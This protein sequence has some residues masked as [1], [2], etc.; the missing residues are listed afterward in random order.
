[1]DASQFVC[2]DINANRE[3]WD[4]AV[5]RVFS[6]CYRDDNDSAT[7][8][9]CLPPPGCTRAVLEAYRIHI[10]AVNYFTDP[11]K[12]SLGD[13]CRRLAKTVM[14]D[15]ERVKREDDPHGQPSSE[16]YGSVQE[17]YK[18]EVEAL[19]G[20]ESAFRKS[21][22]VPYQATRPCTTGQKRRA[23]RRLFASEISSDGSSETPTL[24]GSGFPSTSCN[25]LSH[26]TSPLESSSDPCLSSN[27]TSL[28]TSS[29]E[30]PSEIAPSSV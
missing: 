19:Y 11:I 18:A 30:S 15:L 4:D 9:T 6:R 2:P 27:V 13:R 26:I 8:S 29:S 23:G 24:P 3:N 14:A 10:E 7:L 5:R 20:G 17:A 25:S 16:R 1:M 21:R 12:I 28:P 22:K